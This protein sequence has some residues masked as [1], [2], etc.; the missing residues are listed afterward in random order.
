MPFSNDCKSYVDSGY[1]EGINGI[2]YFS[3]WLLKFWVGLES[4]QV[5]TP[6][7]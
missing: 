7:F 2:K 5:Y 1:A 3:L 6:F 4:L